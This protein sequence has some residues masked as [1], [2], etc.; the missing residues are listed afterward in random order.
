MVRHAYRRAGLDARVE[1]FLDT[2]DQEMGAADVVLCRAGATTL[3]ELTAVGRPAIL[4]PLPWA[5]NAHQLKNAE[6]L[7][8]AGAAEMIDQASLSGHELARRLL[9]LA[10]DEPRR[11]RM[12][13][14]GFV[15]S[16]AV[17]RNSSSV[18]VHCL[19]RSSKAADALAL[20]A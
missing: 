10:S 19:Q 16:A 8:E 7:T 4:V 14:S 5:A 18:P 13:I 12:A 11:A 6:V 1:A 3:A 9:A 20:T 17:F 2:V 15:E